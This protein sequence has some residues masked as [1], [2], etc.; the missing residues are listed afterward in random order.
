MRAYPRIIAHRCGGA[1]AAENSRAGLAAAARIGCRG[2][3][4]DTQLS[5]DGVPV[6]MHDDTV[7]RTTN[8]RGRVGEL[9][10]AELRRMDLGGEPVPTLVEA[11]A[12][13]DRLGLWAN[14]ELKPPVGGEAELG[15]VV[16]G[17]LAERWSGHGVVSSFADEALIASRRV[18]ADLDYA[19]LVPA[20]PSDWLA[21]VRDVGAVAVHTA[22][23]RLS[24]EA[25]EAVQDAGFV[26]ACY[27]VNRREEAEHLLAHGVAVFTDHP[28]FW[29]PGE[30]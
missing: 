13:C 23:S 5:V 21:R 20:L 19:L 24:D 6:L 29:R 3:E 25:R 1:L 14:V 30:M 27:T 22:A 10:L 9:S 7:N 4:F 17:L 28:D 8:G 2:V 16:G 26:L 12:D 11:L 18:A 15:R